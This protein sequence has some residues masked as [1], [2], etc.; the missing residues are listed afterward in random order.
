MKVPAQVA[1][2]CQSLI[3]K[4]KRKGDGLRRMRSRVMCQSLIGKGKPAEFIEKYITQGRQCQ[5]LIGKGKLRVWGVS[6][7]CYLV[8]IPYRKR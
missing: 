4:G 8:S 5:S 3:G 2:M 7:W 6:D 1:E